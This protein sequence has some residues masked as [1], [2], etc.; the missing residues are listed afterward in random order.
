VTI[1]SSGPHRAPAAPA[2]A[3]RGR[4]RLGPADA[5]V[6]ETFVVP[7]YLSL[8][9]ELAL[10]MMAES[11]EAQ[12]VHLHCRTGYPDR[13]ITLKLPGA[14]VIGLDASSAALELARAKAATMPE[15]VSEYR[16]IE[17]LPTHL[18]ASAFSHGIILHPLASPED[19]GKVLAEFC[20]L[21][22]PHGQA[23]M[24][25]PLRGS[26]QELSDLL[27]EYA[28]KYDDNAVGRA[29]EKAHAAKP[30]IETFRAELEDAGFDFVDVSLRPTTL[31][32]QSGRDFFED[33][34]ARMLILP[35]A[36]LNLNLAD[37]EGAFDYVREAIDKYWSDGTFDLTVNVGCATG[38]RL[39]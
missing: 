32:F 13:G 25:M 35:E 36:Q 29:V 17:A 2:A 6:F 3:A 27:R 31:G 33:P 9:G 24:A 15:M 28:L 38:R 39:P 14:H 5:A 4:I 20:R 22:A 34:V 1:E 11:D 23:L 16:L 26:F 10:E 21:L 37:P 7:R 19:R 12:V 8:F 18:P 30:T